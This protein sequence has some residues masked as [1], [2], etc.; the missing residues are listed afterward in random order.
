MDR[1]E[2]RYLVHRI[3]GALSSI[4]R[5]SRIF[6]RYWKKRVDVHISDT[7]YR[8][9]IDTIVQ[10]SISYQ[11]RFYSDIHQYP[12][13]SV[14]IGMANPTPAEPP[15]GEKMAVFMP[16]MRPKLSKSGPPELPGLMAASVCITL[17]IG[18]PLGDFTSLPKPD[19][20][21]IVKE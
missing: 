17:L 18:R 6:C 7:K 5:H 20:T 10:L 15:E 9:R 13:L 4:L 11:T 3:E 21:P 8:N 12:H 16:I 1:I 14:S 19:T 2:K